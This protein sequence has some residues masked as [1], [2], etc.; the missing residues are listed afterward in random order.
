MIIDGTDLILGR[1]ATVV[2]KK[3]LLGENVAIVNCENIK[4]TGTRKNILAKYMRTKSMGVPSKGPFQPKRPDMLVKKTVRGML[5]YKQHKGREALKRVKC[6]I[7]VPEE[8]KEKTET[9]KEANIDKVPHYKNI[10]IKEV[11]KELGWQK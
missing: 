1:V 2:A 10:T 9:V 7:G 5:P 8:F 4:I 6:Y 11:C 3:A